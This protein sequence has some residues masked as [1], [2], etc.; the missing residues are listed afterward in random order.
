VRYEIVSPTMGV[1]MT[2]GYPE[3]LPRGK[4][5]GV[6]RERASGGGSGVVRMGRADELEVTRY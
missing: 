2:L 4:G 6:L 5:A 1:V 3:W